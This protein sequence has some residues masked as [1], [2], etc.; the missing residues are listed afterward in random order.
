AADRG[1]VQSVL[2]DGR[3]R[4]GGSEAGE[5]NDSSEGRR[6]PAAGNDDGDSGEAAA[7][8]QERRDGDGRECEW[9]RGRSSGSGADAGEDCEGAWVEADRT[10]RFVGRGRRRSEHYGDRAGAFDAQGAAV[11]EDEAGA[12]R[13][14]GGE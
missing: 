4:A 13:S 1:R 11:G 2:P 14:G 12:D 8:F 3:D 6:S 10:H 7:V 9:D 5:E